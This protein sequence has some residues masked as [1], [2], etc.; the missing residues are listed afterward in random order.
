MK[1]VIE[2][3]KGG[4]FQDCE[5]VLAAGGHDPRRAGDL[6]AGA[7]LRNRRARSAQHR[8]LQ[9]RVVE[10][11]RRRQAQIF[12][13]LERCLEVEALAHRLARVDRETEAATADTHPLLDI[14]P[15]DV[16][17]VGIE[18]R[19][20]AEQGVLRSEFITPQGIGLEGR[21]PSGWIAGGWEIPERRELLYA[22][23]ADLG[24]ITADAETLGGRGVEHVLRRWF[25]SQPDLRRERVFL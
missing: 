9:L 12:G 7:D 2:A 3:D 22:G 6:I 5:V 14:V 17:R 23:E 13:G 19:A 11:N 8:F 20:T 24:I 15:I 18:L 10:A 25:K 16:V 21:R 1:F 4:G